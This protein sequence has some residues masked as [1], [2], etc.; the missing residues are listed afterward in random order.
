MTSCNL[1]PCLESSAKCRL[2]IIL[3]HALTRTTQKKKIKCLSMINECLSVLNAVACITRNDIA[4][5]GFTSALMFSGHIVI[6][7]INIT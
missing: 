1:S 2:I 5:V 3:I 7:V 4:T 6:Y